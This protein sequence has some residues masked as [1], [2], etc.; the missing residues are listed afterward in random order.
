MLGKCMYKY[1]CLKHLQTQTSWK[2]SQ[3]GGGGWKTPTSSISILVV[4]LDRKEAFAT[5]SY[6]NIL[7]QIKIIF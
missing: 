1:T 5:S 7:K 4:G 6:L 3:N 2:T